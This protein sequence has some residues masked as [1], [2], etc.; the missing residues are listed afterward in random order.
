MCPNMISSYVQL[1]RKIN[2]VHSKRVTKERGTTV[3]HQGNQ[4][5][6]PPYNEL[7]ALFPQYHDLMRQ[8]YC[9]TQSRSKNLLDIRREN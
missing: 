1:I 4:R 2:Y 7:L 9:D 6:P 3:L 5:I 8:T